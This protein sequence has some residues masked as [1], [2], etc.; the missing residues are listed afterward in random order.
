[1][2]NYNIEKLFLNFIKKDKQSLQKVKEFAIDNCLYEL[3]ANIRDMEKALYPIDDKDKID[4]ERALHL[5]RAVK[6]SDVNC[7]SKV[8]FIVE[9]V[10]YEL[11]KKDSDFNLKIAS[12][13][14]TESNRIFG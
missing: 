2:K 10:L 12:D 13:I 3:G 8:A 7:S 11:N 1:M 14:S 6:M 9:K 4:I 5:S